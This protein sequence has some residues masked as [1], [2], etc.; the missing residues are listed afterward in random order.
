M[1]LIDA[2]ALV[3]K[4]LEQC[5]KDCNRRK[6]I[7]RGKWRIVYNIGDAPCRACEIDDFK[8]TLENAPA[9]D[10]VPV[11]RCKDCKHHEAEQP[12]MVYCPHIIGGW[13]EEDGF[14]AG[15]ERKDGGDAHEP[16]LP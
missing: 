15:G 12:G 6:G 5:C 4:A 8:D 7:K 14:C 2:D 11:V 1:K 9:I 3:D 13:V 10:A 16:E